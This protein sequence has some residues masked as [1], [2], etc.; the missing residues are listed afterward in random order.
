MVASS[1]QHSA[2]LMASRPEM[3]QTRRDKNQEP[4]SFNMKL[5]VMK[6][7]DPMIVPV[8]NDVAPT[9]MQQ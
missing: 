3:S 5:A 9:E 8:T 7:P 6:I 2:P 4:T 1:A